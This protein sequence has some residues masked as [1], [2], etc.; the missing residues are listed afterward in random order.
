[1]TGDIQLVSAPQSYRKVSV[2]IVS[3][4][5]PAGHVLENVSRAAAVV[6]ALTE[7]CNALQAAVG[8]LVPAARLEAL[9]SELDERMEEAARLRRAM[10]D[11]VPSGKL[12]RLRDEL[13]TERRLARD[14]A[15]QEERLRREAMEE[16]RRR[17]ELTCVTA[18]ARAEAAEAEASL[19]REG[20]LH[21]ERG[22]AEAQVQLEQARNLAKQAGEEG[23]GL[24]KALL[25][26]V[27]RADLERAQAEAAGLCAD[28]ERLSREMEGMV[29]AARYAAVRADLDESRAEVVRAQRAAE[30]VVTAAE[31]RAAQ[32][33]VQSLS[34]EVED[35][36]RRLLGTVSSEE[37]AK[38]RREAA[39]LAAEAARLA[40]AVRDSVPRA[41]HNAACRELDKLQEEFGRAQR[42]G[43]ALSLEN[44]ELRRRAAAAVPREELTRAREQ[45]VEL[46]S[47]VERLKWAAREAVPRA[48]HD[49]L[50]AE[51]E[52][53]RVEMGAVAEGRA[54]AA[55]AA[56]A[57]LAAENERL[58]QRAMEAAAEKEALQDC[59]REVDALALDNGRLRRLAESSVSQANSMSH[60]KVLRRRKGGSRINHLHWECVLVL[61]DLVGVVGP[62]AM[63][64]LGSVLTRAL[65]EGDVWGSR[66]ASLRRS[67]S[68]K[69]AGTTSPG[70][71]ARSTM[72]CRDL[73]EMPGPVACVICCLW[74]GRG[75]GLNRI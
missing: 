71:A 69:S 7:E 10:D 73:G 70:L 42:V 64:G 24:R 33:A 53:G 28:L 46:S 56:A 67:E 59:R 21:A 60:P 5:G 19:C 50:R 51:L 54:R 35:L 38:A 37:H 62:V 16:E 27:P 11:M 9:R 6:S 17:F 66:C 14:A 22:F 36:R 23:D 30:G 31:H 25:A 4:L 61:A 52:Q 58:M 43:E 18:A 48:E 55:E 8:S 20:L 72:L 68:W 39:A 12:K 74:T 34:Q 44:Q 45:I 40:E 3:E 49:A 47:E 63:S 65:M 41:Q 1:M 29:P 75:Q 26:A 2:S 13:E 57:A 32:Q 15:S